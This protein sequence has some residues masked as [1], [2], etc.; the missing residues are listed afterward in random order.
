MSS[1]QLTDTLRIVKGITNFP[2]HSMCHGQQK[3]TIYLKLWRRVLPCKMPF[4]PYD[5]QQVTLQEYLS[6]A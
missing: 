3:I 4:V 5:V 2:L 6:K 1:H